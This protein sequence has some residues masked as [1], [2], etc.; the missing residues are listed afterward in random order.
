[1]DAMSLDALK[2]SFD[3]VL[4]CGMLHTFNDRGREL[5]RRSLERVLKV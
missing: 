1:M 5:Y 3:T 4:D 2:T